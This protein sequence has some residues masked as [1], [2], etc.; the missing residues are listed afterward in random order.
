MA[1]PPSGQCSA[2]CRVTGSDLCAAR[3]DTFFKRGAQHGTRSAIL[4]KPRSGIT[5]QSCG[6]TVE[7][8]VH[9]EEQRT[10]IC[11]SAGAES[12]LPIL[13]SSAAG[14][15]RVTRIPAPTRIRGI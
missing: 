13:V 10:P 4:A 8:R 6:A 12:L 9:T 11:P 7:R 14:P 5:S 15:R 1:L 3:G 2:R